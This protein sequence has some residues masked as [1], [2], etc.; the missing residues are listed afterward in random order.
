MVNVAI[1]ALP[2][3]PAT[4]PVMKQEKVSE[5]CHTSLDVERRH[6]DSVQVVF[7][8]TFAETAIN[9]SFIFVGLKPAERQDVDQGLGGGR[10]NN[11]I[12]PIADDSMCFQSKDLAH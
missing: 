7:T 3:G 6:I 9:K 2:C 11:E 8:T 5:F 4:D 10:G 12:I 1:V